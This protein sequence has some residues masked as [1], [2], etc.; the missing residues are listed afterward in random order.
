MFPKMIFLH[1]YM[2]SKDNSFPNFMCFKGVFFF[3]FYHV[4]DGY[5]WKTKKTSQSERFENMFEKS[6][7]VIITWS[8]IRLCEAV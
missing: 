6:I 2:C 7:G 4:S 3:M 1:D 8:G 5:C